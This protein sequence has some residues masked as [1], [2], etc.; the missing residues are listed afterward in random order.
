MLNK[1]LSLIGGLV[2]LL[3]LAYSGAWFYAA[4]KLDGA[5][6]E[7]YERNTEDDLKLHAPAPTIKGFPFAPSATF[8]EGL[9]Y[10]GVDFI[11]E[12]MTV[13][14]YA[15]AGLPVTV[16]IPEGVRVATALQSNVITL[17]EVKAS[18]SAPYGIPELYEEDLRAWQQEGAVIDVNFYQAT[19]GP[20]KMHGNGLITLDQDLQPL[21]TLATKATGYEEL[22]GSLEAA[23]NMSKVAATGAM[24]ALNGLAEENPETGVKTVKL[25]VILQYQKLRIGPLAIAQF[26]EIYWDRRTPPDQPL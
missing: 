26:P 3:A 20:V 23:G 6:N 4:H 14:G 7:L 12:E 10:K 16:H 25:T 15:L 17:T 21:V 19:M 1:F 18:V 22:I 5:L 13:S 24:L 2:L 8:K 11:F 9:T